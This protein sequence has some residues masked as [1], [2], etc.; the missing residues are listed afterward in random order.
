MIQIV[1]CY[2]HELGWLAERAGCEIGPGFQAMKAVDER[3]RV[4]G[5]VGY[6]GW[7]ANSFLMHIALDNPA[8]LRSL[9]KWCFRY[10]FEQAGRGVAYAT[11]RG[12]NEPSLRLCRKVGFREVCRLRDAVAVG[13][14]MV[15]FEM[16]REECRW[17]P[18]VVRKAA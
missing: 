7:T 18:D 9:L 4:H 5:M 15:L 8:C 1:G 10:P 14:D 13:E 6:G 11:V 2:D 12:T 17:I 3:G 16:R